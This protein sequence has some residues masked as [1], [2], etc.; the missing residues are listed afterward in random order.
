LNAA[1]RLKYRPASF[2]SRPYDLRQC[3]NA[4]IHF[5]ILSCPQFLRGQAGS[6]GTR[7]RNEL[8][9][10]MPLSTIK[11][12]LAGAGRPLHASASPAAAAPLARRS[13][14][15][16]LHLHISDS[17]SVV[18]RPRAIQF[19]RQPIKRA[20]TAIGREK[21]DGRADNTFVML[22]IRFELL[23]FILSARQWNFTIF[24][25]W[26]ITQ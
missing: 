13:M 21:Y 4:L 20:N 6:I 25:Y 7:A 11:S 5:A 12:R 17:S 3:N 16:K 8:R 10:K 14:H 22:S 24:L 23:I 15:A 18:R 19:V 9:G 2:Q 26:R 1:H